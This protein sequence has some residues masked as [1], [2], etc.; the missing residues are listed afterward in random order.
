MWDGAGWWLLFA[1]LFGY[2]YF[3]GFFFLPKTHITHMKEKFSPAP[4]SISQ[5]NHRK[6]LTSQLPLQVQPSINNPLTSAAG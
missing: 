1:H 2:L 4:P 3:L 6:E 5:A